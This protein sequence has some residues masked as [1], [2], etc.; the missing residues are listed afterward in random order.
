TTPRTPTSRC[1]VLRAALRIL[2]FVAQFN[3]SNSLLSTVQR[4]QSR[5]LNLCPPIAHV[6]CRHL[7]GY[8]P[9]S[10]CHR[11]LSA[12]MKSAN[13]LRCHRSETRHNFISATHPR[14]H[15]HKFFC[16]TIL[17]CPGFAFLY[18]LRRPSVTHSLCPK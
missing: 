14:R 9:S 1:L 10:S 5:S 18:L 15:H 2:L 13:T 11:S 7:A 6:R 3:H 16:D 12:K 8:F 17:G 4:N